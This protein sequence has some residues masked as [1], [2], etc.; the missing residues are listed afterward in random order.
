MAEQ[1]DMNIEDMKRL[2][3]EFKKL[4]KGSGG[5]GSSVV[6]GGGSGSSK[7]EGYDQVYVKVDDVNHVADVEAAIKEIGYETSSMSH[8][9]GWGCSGERLL[10]K[11][12]ALACKP[13]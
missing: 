11:A 9:R 2:E 5:G 12:E 4:S 7:I 6:I 1:R 10:L 8:T 13:H 3:E